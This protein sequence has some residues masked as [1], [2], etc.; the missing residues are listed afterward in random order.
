VRANRAFKVTSVECADSCITCPCRE[1][2]AAMHILPV[3]FQAGDAIGKIE[4]QL[5]ITTD[6][7]EGVVPSVTV[8][9]NVE[10][11]SAAVPTEQVQSDGKPLGVESD[12]PAAGVQE[13]VE[14]VQPNPKQAGRGTPSEPTAAPST[15]PPAAEP[16]P[17]ATSVGSRLIGRRAA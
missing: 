5:M 9:A 4:R 7:G 14:P 8:Q 16:A 12:T 11:V 2:A 10:G 1:T 15:A 3:T 6:L 17:E 13:S